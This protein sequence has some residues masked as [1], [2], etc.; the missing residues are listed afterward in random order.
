MLTGV[1]MIRLLNG[2]LAP[3]TR[4]ADTQSPW[5]FLH[6]KQ[7]QKERNVTLIINETLASRYKM[8]RWEDYKTNNM[9]GPHDSLAWRCSPTAGPGSKPCFVLL[10]SIL[11]KPGTLCPFPCKEWRHSKEVRVTFGNWRVHTIT[12]LWEEREKKESHPWT[13][14]T[15]FF[16][17]IDGYLFIYRFWLWC[18]FFLLIESNC[19]YFHAFLKLKT[20]THCFREL[21]TVK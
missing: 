2:H 8:R 11:P 17:P 6:K 5:E 14:S 12:Q 3:G 4:H 20:H 15:S 18:F 9:H 7:W 16:P 21:S 1:A 10:L 13:A 19:I